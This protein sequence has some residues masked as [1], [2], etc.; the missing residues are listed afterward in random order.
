MILCSITHKMCYVLNYSRLYL[1]VSTVTHKVPLV[2]EGLA[3]DKLS[4]IEI[5]MLDDNHEYFRKL[6]CVRDVNQIKWLYGRSCLSVLI[7]NQNR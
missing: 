2:K 7:V 6:F 1:I 4:C 3:V 5:M